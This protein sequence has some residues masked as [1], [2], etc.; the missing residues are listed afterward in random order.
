MLVLKMSTKRRNCMEIHLKWIFI[1]LLYWE[2][3]K[4]VSNAYEMRRHLQSTS[5][6]LQGWS[7][8]FCYWLWCNPL[9]DNLSPGKDSLFFVFLSLSCFFCLSATA[10]GQITEHSPAF[11]L[12]F[13]LI[14]CNPCLSASRLRQRFGSHYH[15]V[16]WWLMDPHKSSK[17]AV[18]SRWWRVLLSVST[19]Q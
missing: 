18:P 9:K 7:F 5:T 3:I 14:W 11:S 8:L 6:H 15:P 2:E 12:L 13:K 17:Q 19:L 4:L 10:K 16:K 1:Q